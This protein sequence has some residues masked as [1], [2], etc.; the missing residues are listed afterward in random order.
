MGG[1]VCGAIVGVV[2]DKSRMAKA[3]VLASIANATSLQSDWVRICDQLSDYAGAFGIALVPYVTERRAQ[4]VVTSRS[5]EQFVSAYI[6]E[7][8]YK[9][10]VRPWCPCHAAQGLCH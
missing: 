6:N 8:W 2:G 3:D 9:A 5:L 10:D 7:G 1:N 4:V